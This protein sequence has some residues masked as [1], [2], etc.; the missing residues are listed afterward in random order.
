VASGGLRLLLCRPIG[1]ARI[2]FVKAITAALVATFSVGAFLAMA[3][4][5]GLVAVGFGDL[6]IYP[7]VLQMTDQHQHLPQ[8]TALLRFAMVWPLASLALFT[9][10]SLAL[11]VATLTRS[12]VNAVGISIALYLTLYVIAEIHFFRDL[13]PWL[14]TSSMAYWR[15][16]FREDIPWR[17]IAAEASKLTGFSLLFLSLAYRRFRLREEA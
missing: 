17:S 10:L 11:L 6:D 4:L 3:L 2:F 9:P 14:F 16:L 5:L 15:A 8:G 7:G 12:P 13:R 1:K